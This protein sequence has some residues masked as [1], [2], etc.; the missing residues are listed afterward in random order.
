MNALKRWGWL[1]LVMC[2]MAY[3]P[4]SHAVSMSYVAQD[5][6]DVNPGEDL[7][8]Y[9]YS[10]GGSLSLFGGI[11]FLFAPDQYGE[12]SNAEPSA[13]PDW[14]VSVVQPDPGLPAEGLYSLLTLIAPP[15]F[16]GPFSVDFVWLGQGVPGSQPFEVFDDSFVVIEEGRTAPAGSAPEPSTLALAFAVLLPLVLARRLT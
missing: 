1:C 5:L 9:Q 11:N 7:W 8:R 3:L 13:S 4:S 15:D 2:G 10:I 16:T 12:L 6:A 14:S